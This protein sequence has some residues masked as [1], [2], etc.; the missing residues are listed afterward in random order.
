MTTKALNFNE[1]SSRYAST[2]LDG[3]GLIGAPR[4]ASAAG[5]ARIAYTVI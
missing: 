1:G 5:P 4:I 2:A 3:I